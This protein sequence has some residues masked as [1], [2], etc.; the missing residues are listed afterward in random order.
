MQLYRDCLRLADYI[1]TRGGNGANSRL[2]L[3]AQ[4]RDAFKRNKDEQDPA[5]VEKQKDA[6]IRGL[7]NYMFYEA[8]RMAKEEGDSEGKGELDG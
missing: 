8:Q 4:V 7:S 5:E 3:R 1:S 2:V 6:A